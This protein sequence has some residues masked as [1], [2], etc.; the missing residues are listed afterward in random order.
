MS[1]MRF[2]VLRFDRRPYRIA[3]GLEPTAPTEN[4]VSDVLAIA[5][6]VGEPVPLV[7][8]SSGAVVALEAAP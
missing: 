2:R 4:E 3:G 5:A 7:G 8:Y 1:G 6:F